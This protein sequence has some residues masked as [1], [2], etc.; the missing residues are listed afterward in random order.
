MKRILIIATITIIITWFLLPIVKFIH[1]KTIGKND[2]DCMIK[3][4]QKY[5]PNGWTYLIDNKYPHID[6]QNLHYE[7]GKMIQT[8]KTDGCI[9]HDKSLISSIINTQYCY[10]T[11][12]IETIINN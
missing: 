9:I 7:A 3:Y 10:T 5:Y 11:L 4:V 2:T 6:K 1:A 12:F 8:W